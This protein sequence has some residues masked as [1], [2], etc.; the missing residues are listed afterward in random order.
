MNNTSTTNEE[1]FFDYPDP[2]MKNQSGSDRLQFRVLNQL[3][4][5]RYMIS[6]LLFSV[7]LFLIPIGTSFLAYRLFG[8]N[9]ILMPVLLCSGLFYCFY[10]LLF[11][12][13]MIHA[14]IPFLNE[15][16]EKLGFIED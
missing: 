3:L 15:W 14:R 10:S 7:T 5:S 6:G 4:P 13:L 11:G 16:K 8:S 12:F 9:A 1:S 2:F